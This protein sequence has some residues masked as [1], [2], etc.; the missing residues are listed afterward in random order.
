MNKV[1]YVKYAKYV[2]SLLC[3]FAGSAHAQDISGL[4]PHAEAGKTAWE[5]FGIIMGGIMAGTI[6]IFFGQIAKGIAM[7]FTVKRWNLISPDVSYLRFGTATGF[8][9]SRVKK[10]GLFA[11]H[12]RCKDDNGNTVKDRVPHSMLVNGRC[13][14][15]G[16]KA[17]EK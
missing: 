7:G 3:V 8:Y 11:V 5:I 17:I 15:V 6:V 1:K 9:D 16:G 14:I 12:C 4:I 10:I 2:V 13:T